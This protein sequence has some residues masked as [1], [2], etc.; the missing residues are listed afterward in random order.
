MSDELAIKPVTF[1]RLDEKMSI[2]PQTRAPKRVITRRRSNVVT[3]VTS[4][5]NANNIHTSTKKETL[6][7]TLIVGAILYVGA[8]TLARM[9]M[10]LEVKP[11]GTAVADAATITET[12]DQEENVNALLRGYWN[13]DVRSDIGSPMGQQVYIDSKAM[14]KLEAGDVIGINFIGNSASGDMMVNLE[15][16]QWF[17][18]T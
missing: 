4:S 16:I 13:A 2:L 11:N 8:G 6:I 3:T 18:Q 9:N 15:I 17:K 7:R 10:L 12:L 5:Q 1:K 14:R